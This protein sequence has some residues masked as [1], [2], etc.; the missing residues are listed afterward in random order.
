MCVATTCTMS[1]L[2]RLASVCSFACWD[3]SYDYET[4]DSAAANT[5]MVRRTTTCLVAWGTLRCQALAQSNL[6][7]VVGY[8][9]ATFAFLHCRLWK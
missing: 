3:A 4:V 7:L 5:M 8:F 9:T 2:N 6:D 1:L